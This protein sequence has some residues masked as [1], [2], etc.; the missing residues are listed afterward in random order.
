MRHYR[1][2]LYCTCVAMRNSLLSLA[3]FSSQRTEPFIICA[4]MDSWLGLAYIVPMEQFYISN[5]ACIDGPDLGVCKD[6]SGPTG[7]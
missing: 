6:G 7:T 1:Y 5:C 4:L 3:Y 2:I